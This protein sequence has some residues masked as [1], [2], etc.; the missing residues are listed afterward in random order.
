MKETGE[1][2]DE[3]GITF[4]QQLGYGIKRG[5]GGGGGCVISVDQLCQ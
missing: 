2:M 4:P 3:R 1:H 5:G